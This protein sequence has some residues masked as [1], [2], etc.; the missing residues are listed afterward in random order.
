MVFKKYFDEVQVSFISG[1]ITPKFLNDEDNLMA[2]NYLIKEESEIKQVELV[3]N[4]LITFRENSLSVYQLFESSFEK[5][6]EKE[7]NGEISK[8]ISGSTNKFIVVLKNKIILMNLE[9]DVDA[10]EKSIPN[11][12]TET[13]LKMD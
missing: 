11:L 7:L 2:S 5:I 4:K 6:Y 8:I 13:D 9:S 10:I 12:N 1:E 3:G